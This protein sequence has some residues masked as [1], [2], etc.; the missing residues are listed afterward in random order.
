MMGG[1]M[2][3]EGNEKKADSAPKGAVRKRRTYEE[4]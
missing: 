3:P 2:C 4:K 1:T